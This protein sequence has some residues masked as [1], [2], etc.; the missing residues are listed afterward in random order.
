[1]AFKTVF[2]TFISVKPSR[3]EGHT[4]VGLLVMIEPATARQALCLVP[5]QAG[6]TPL[7]APATAS[8]CCVP[9]VAQGAGAHALPAGLDV[10]QAEMDT[11][12]A[13]VCIGAIAAFVPTLRMAQT[14]L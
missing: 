2:L 3:T 14:G 1:M 12:Q 13:L 5:A 10:P 8:C 9:K 11:V 6:L 4:G 7:V